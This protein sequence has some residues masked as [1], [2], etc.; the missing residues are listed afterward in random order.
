MYTHKEGL[1][2]MSDLNNNIPGDGTQN[3]SEQ[4]QGNEY[5]AHSSMEQGQSETQGAGYNNQQPGGQ[6]Q[7][8]GSYHFAGNPYQAPP[9]SGQ[10]QYNAFDRSRAPG[11]G[12]VYGQPYGPNQKPP[13]PKKS[14]KKLAGWKIALIVVLCVAIVAAG[15]GGGVYLA[16]RDTNT[17]SVEVET[18]DTPQISMEDIPE[19]GALT[20]EQIA[21]RVKPSVVAILT[22]NN[23]TSASG[24][25]VVMGEDS[26]HTYTYF[27]TCAHMLDD[28]TNAVVQLED[29]TQ[30]DAEIVGY[31]NRTDIGVVRVKATGFTA[32][33]FGDSTQLQ[34]G[35]DVYAIG[36]PGGTSFYGSFTE[37]IVSA[38]DRPVNS[39]QGYTQVCIQHTAAI[40]SGN[41]GGALINEY[42]Q[43]IGI[44][45]SKIADS[46]FEGMGFAVPISTALSVAESIIA[47]G[48]VPGRPMLG[49][50][51]MSVYAN[52]TYAVIAQVANLPQGSI[53]VS[54][55][56][57]QSS[58]TGTDVQV[59]DIITQVNGHDL[60]TSD[61]LR[62]VVDNASVG[63]TLTLTIC[64]VNAN[65]ELSQFNVQITLIED[66]GDTTYSSSSSSQQEDDN[67]SNSGG[68]GGFG[69]NFFWP[70]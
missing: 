54:S 5:Q 7:V 62:E 6:Q 12:Q 68:S 51:Y 58:F 1:N 65:Y 26:T 44:N 15:V 40:N 11:S 45:S 64:R 2:T 13:K 57:N 22:Y 30:Y 53:V 56:A 21:A 46:S 36:N 66:K 24:S 43:V 8:N 14:G 41:S 52:S 33:E 61:S 18:Q 55:I 39:E 10:Y 50:Q 28:F 42:G 4:P 16:L 9:A 29:E 70:F 27:L 59:G 31:D 17:G 34:V 25:G 32:A 23:T 60:E 48:Y 49:I 19:S 69:G 67:N 35:N 20:P 3:S 47:N 63:D 38:I 37:G